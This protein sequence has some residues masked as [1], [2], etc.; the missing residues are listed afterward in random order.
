ML[1]M[2]LEPLADQIPGIGLVTYI[3]FRSGIALM[4][5]FLLCV[6]VGEPLINW[7][8]ARQGKGQPIRDLSLEAQMSKQGT[9]T[10][11]RFPNLAGSIG[12]HAFMGRPSKPIYLGDFVCDCLFCNSWLF[13]R[14]C[15]GHQAIHRWRVL[16]SKI[17]G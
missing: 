1:Y 5:A 16:Q 2:Y 3:T 13:R 11:G 4:T 17:A 9:P 14:L 6:L 10:M 7:L 8:R 12:I 15:K